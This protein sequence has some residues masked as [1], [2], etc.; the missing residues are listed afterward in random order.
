ME[1]FLMLIDKINELKMLAITAISAITGS[2]LGYMSKLNLDAAT[3]PAWFCDAKP[4]L[5]TM[6]WVV[7]I[8]A[9]IATTIKVIASFRKKKED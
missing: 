9:G 4:V 2:A 8:I 1:F 3:D 5:Q 7:A 6:A